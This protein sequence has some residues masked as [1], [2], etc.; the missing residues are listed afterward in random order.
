[1]GNKASTFKKE[2]S[3]GLTKL[4]WAAFNGE[5]DECV[6]LLQKRGANINVNI[7]GTTPLHLAVENGHK[8]IVQYFCEKGALIYFLNDKGKTPIQLGKDLFK[9]SEKIK[10]TVSTFL[11]EKILEMFYLNST[12][13]FGIPPELVFQLFQ[14]SNW[15]T[16]TGGI[17]K[18]KV[19]FK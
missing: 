15:K 1:M 10:R 19:E 4:H 9:K 2:D 18:F 8:K 5:L 14:T 12:L 11:E 17:P 16:N 7:A 3:F 6:K 13:N